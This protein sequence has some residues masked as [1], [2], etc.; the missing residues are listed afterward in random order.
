MIKIEEEVE[1]MQDELWGIAV[2][3]VKKVS[4]MIDVV[5]TIVNYISNHV[6]KEVLSEVQRLHTE[7]MKDRGFKILSRVRLIEDESRNDD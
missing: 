5:Q 2:N 6:D 1:E 3:E 4:E 7:K